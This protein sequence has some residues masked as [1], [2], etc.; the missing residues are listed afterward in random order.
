MGDTWVGLPYTICRGSVNG[1]Y[2]PYPVYVTWAGAREWE[3]TRSTSSGLAGHIHMGAHGRRGT[4]WHVRAHELHTGG[5]WGAHLEICRGPIMCTQRLKEQGSR[6]LCSI[7]TSTH[8]CPSYSGARITW[9]HI[10]EWRGHMMGKW[11]LCSSTLP[12]LSV[13]QR[14]PHHRT[15]NELRIVFIPWFDAQVV[16]LWTRGRGSGGYPHRVPIPWFDA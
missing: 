15:A 3:Q 4:C 6:E 16:D 2:T 13:V 7:H 5:K 14:H 9:G 10:H 1:V 11:G 12:H 8:T